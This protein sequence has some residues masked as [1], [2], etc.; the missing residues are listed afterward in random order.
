VYA[1]IQELLD[2]NAYGYQELCNAYSSVQINLLRAIAKEKVVEQ[3][4]A[5]DFVTKY[6]LKNASSISGAMQK[7]LKNELVYKSEE[8]YLVYDRFFSLWLENR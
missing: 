3:I 5:G 7:L 2:E 8:G 6:K 1:A 4:T